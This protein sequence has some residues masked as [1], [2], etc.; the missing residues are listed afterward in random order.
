M[1]PV[2]DLDPVLR[3]ASLIGLVAALRNVHAGF[4]IG[5][6]YNAVAPSTD[7]AL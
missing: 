6:A 4:T 2:L 3:A 7:E 1:L 5:G